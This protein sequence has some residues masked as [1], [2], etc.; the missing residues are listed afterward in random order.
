VSAGA[1]PAPPSAPVH[2]WHRR[3]S[4]LAGGGGGGI[5]AGMA[6]TTPAMI[7][8]RPELNSFLEVTQS[9]PH[10]FLGMHPVALK[11][12]RGVVVRAFLANAKECAV[13]PLDA[14]AG[15]A[16]KKSFPLTR[17]DDAGFFEG[18]IPVREIFPY[19][20][21]VTGY[22]GAVRTVRDPY[23][24]WPTLGDTD[25]YLINEGTE[26]RLYEKLGSRVLTHQGV[27]G[28]AFAVWAPSARRVSLVG[29]FN[30]WDG[31]YLPMRKLGASGVWEIFV[32]ALAAGVRYKYEILGPAEPTPFL[33]SDPCALYF[34]PPPNNASIVFDLRKTDWRDAE[35]LARRAGTDWRRAPVS[36]YEMHL[37]SWRRVPEENNRP[38]TYRELAEQLPAYLVAEGFTHVEFLPPA[39]HPFD[40]SWGYQV[41]GFYAPTQRF[42]TPLDFCALV[43]ALHTAGIG[44]IVD[45]VPA[46]FPRDAFALAGFDGT[47]LYEHA[48]PRQ[49]TQREWG[50]LIFNYGRHEVRGFL[51]GAALAWFDRFHIDGLR[52]DAVASMLYLDYARDAGEWVP[53]KFGGRENLDAA[54]F[55]RYVNNAVHTLYPG[56]LTIAEES[57]SYAGVT[58][59]VAAGGLGFD[60]KWNMGWMHDTLDYL[61]LDPLHRRWHHDKLTFGMLYQYSEAFTQVFS[62]DEVVHGKSSLINK[63][64][65]RDVAARAQNLR[66][67]LA[68][69]WT[70]PGKKTLFMGCEFGQTAEWKFDASLDWHL[71]RYP[72][73]AGL[74]LLVRDLNRLYTGTPAIAALDNDPRGFQWVEPD[75]KENS[76]LTFLR[77]SDGSALPPRSPLPADRSAQTWLVALNFTPVERDYRCGVP[78]AGEWR[79]VIN[80]DARE[81]GGAGAGNLGGVI[82]DAGVSA[83][84]RPHSLRFRLPGMSAVIFCHSQYVA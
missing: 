51:T 1:A 12:R 13:V 22:D 5:V 32:P 11:R 58:R 60:L 69:L 47:H 3:Q 27:A 17:L 26:H 74:Q 48:D 75:D 40:G 76:V 29:D 45:W 16:S 14:A 50:T 38:L 56:A 49:G 84:G 57:T 71:L 4:R 30:N 23:S 10:T 62:H 19:A 46:H 34:E 43:D 33:K 53:N 82:A 37:G 8:T 61:H 2:R 44:V 28:V 41:T 70:W 36:I 65:Q 6:S 55:L 63:M 73:H 79:E 24:F 25:L 78:F 72:D 54:D 68:Y 64:P 67:L 35:W 42:G 21:R 31:R 77:F 81:Y 66:V 20:L 7:L 83:H 52:V 9:Q 59:P 15:G 18:F 39:E 80:T